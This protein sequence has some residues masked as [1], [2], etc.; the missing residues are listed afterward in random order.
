MK[1]LFLIVFTFSCGTLQSSKKYGDKG[2]S[3][4]A[5]EFSDQFSTKIAVVKSLMKEKKYEAAQVQLTKI[6]DVDL[7]KTEKTEKYNVLGMIYYYQKRYQIAKASFQRALSFKTENKEVENQAKINLSSTMY[8]M[9]HFER[10]LSVLKSVKASHLSERDN[11]KVFLLRYHLAKQLSRPTEEAY[12]LMKLLSFETDRDQ[13]INHKY[14]SLLKSKFLG[15]SFEKQMKIFTAFSAERKNL[16]IEELAGSLK[17]NL[18]EKGEEEKLKSFESWYGANIRERAKVVGDESR[19]FEYDII[20]KI[21]VQKIGVL[22]PLTGDKGSFGKKALAGLELAKENLA[23]EFEVLVKDSLS[24]VEGSLSA[25]EKLAKED[26]VAA[27]IG[28]LFSSTAKDEYLLC[29]KYGIIY[30][31]LSPLQIDQDLKD[32]LLVEVPGSIESQVNTLFT[33]SVAQTLG[34][35]FAL[36]F[37]QDDLGKSYLDQ[38]WQKSQEE[39]FELASISGYDPAENDHRVAIGNLVGVQFSKKREEE[40]RDLQKEYKKKEKDLSEIDLMKPI[41]EFDWVFIPSYPKKAL[42]IIPS[43]KYLGVK[44]VAF[45]GGPSWKSRSLISRREYLGKVYFVEDIDVQKKMDFINMYR[46]KYQK[47]PHLL[48]TLGFDSIYLASDLLKDLSVTNRSEVQS[49]VMLKNDLSSFLGHW[50]RTDSLWVKKMQLTDLK[51]TLK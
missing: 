16:V 41:I 29:K 51:A 10:S 34:R 37:P 38:I 6:L 45:V 14:F 2:N 17:A 40:L 44:R 50:V 26:K 13:L 30:I 33:P 47:E 23:G 20:E 24:T 21:E 42:Q 25:I 8:K 31:S 35:R 39:D 46:Q 28:G 7:N 48:E 43:F 9:S 22:L 32:E 19:D 1:F 36:F 12:S 3:K 27:I 11:K 15:I 49:Q 4:Q 5:K 18:E